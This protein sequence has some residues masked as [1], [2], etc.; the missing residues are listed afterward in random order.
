[1]SFTIE[2]RASTK[3]ILQMIIEEKI[4]TLIDPVE[5]LY[6]RDGND[7]LAKIIGFANFNI[8]EDYMLAYSKTKL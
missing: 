4:L 6:S 7:F 8:R 1:M 2:V 5:V 3:L